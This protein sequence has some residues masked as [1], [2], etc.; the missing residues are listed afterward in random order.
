MTDAIEG[1][2][3]CGVVQVRVA[4]APTELN[5]CQCEHC[6]K[7]GTLWAY[8]PKEQ[9]EVSGPTS[10]YR[11]GPETIN[12]HFCGCCG[13]TTHWSSVDP[14]RS[15]MGVN[16]RLFGKAIFQSIPQQKG[17]GPR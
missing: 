2:C 1:S 16:A 8:Y 3:H 6:Q 11:W 10:I 17:G 4:S 5:D 12:F 9:V 14:K 13:C 15:R 7:R